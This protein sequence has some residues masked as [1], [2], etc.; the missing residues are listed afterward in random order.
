MEDKIETWIKEE[1]MA[2]ASNVTIESHNLLKKCS[3]SGLSEQECIAVAFTLIFSTIA[4]Q[5]A[6][7]TRDDKLDEGVSFILDM[8]L[9]KK[10]KLIKMCQLIN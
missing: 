9:H 8:L 4:I 10:E 3:A 2:I 7:F 5:I 1:M 6:T